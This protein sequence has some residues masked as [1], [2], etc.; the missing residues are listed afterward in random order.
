MTIQ[1]IDCITALADQIIPLGIF[2]GQSH[3]LRSHDR[4]ERTCTCH[5]AQPGWAAAA[6]TRER[7]SRI[8]SFANAH[9]GSKNVCSAR[10]LCIYAR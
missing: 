8:W 2:R 5:S 1:R 4:R 7:K 3:F 9:H 10:I 6:R